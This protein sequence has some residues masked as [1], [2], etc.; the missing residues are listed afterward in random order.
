MT[1]LEFN[2]KFST[3]KS[4]IDHFLKIRYKEG[5]VCPHCGSRIRISRYRQ[6]IKFIQ[7]NDCNNT[8]SVF[9]GT[10]FEHSSTDLTKWFY[11]IHLVLNAKKGISGYQLKREIGVTYKCAWRMLRQIRLAMGNINEEPIFKAIVEIDETYIG[12]KPRRFYNQNNR[13]VPHPSGMYKRGRGTKKDVVVGIKE[14]TSGLVHAEVVLP[15]I[16]GKR[17]T[18][19]QLLEIIK[20]VCKN[21]TTVITDD[22]RG[23]DVLNKKKNHTF[24][25]YYVNHSMHQYSDGKGIHTNG[26]ESFWSILKRSWYGIYHH[27]STKYLQNYV[28][29]CCFRNN[30]RNDLNIFDS[31]LKQ[32][33]FG[34]QSISTTVQKGIA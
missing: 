15:N 27:I 9:T 12:G 4:V 10:I 18:G 26:I 11:A 28:N 3:D 21:R 6:R 25:R 14:R 1:F 19:N 13:I 34:R 2:E 32:S 20:K 7:C 24:Q 8:F 22:F 30:H 5:L 31:L 33:D 16:Q 29:E 17:L 23:Y